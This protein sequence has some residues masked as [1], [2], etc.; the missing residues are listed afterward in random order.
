MSNRLINEIN[1]V[2][3]L[4]QPIKMIPKDAV[5]KADNSSKSYKVCYN[6]FVLD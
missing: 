6:Q 4:F 5:L 2:S 1:R 3:R